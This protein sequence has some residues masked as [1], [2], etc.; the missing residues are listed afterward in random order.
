MAMSLR[1][2]ESLPESMKALLRRVAI[3]LELP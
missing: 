3:D 1:D 2:V